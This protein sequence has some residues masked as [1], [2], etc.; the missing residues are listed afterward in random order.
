MEGASAKS[1]NGKAR[2]WDHGRGGANQLCA[3]RG[4]FQIFAPRSGVTICQRSLGAALAAAPGH[5]TQPQ[6]DDVEAHV[7]ALFVGLQAPMG[8]DEIDCLT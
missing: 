7:L 8:R 1:H 5:A 6:S 4:L 3:S 2:R